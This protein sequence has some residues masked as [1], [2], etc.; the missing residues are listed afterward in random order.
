M[1]K[2]RSPNRAVREPVQVYLAP[3]DRMLLEQVAEATGLSRAEVLR[4]GLRTFA[5]AARGAG[6]P[7]LE[8][9][10]RLSAEEWPDA[11]AERHDE[12]LAQA[13]YPPEKPSRKA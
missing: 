3:D 12:H 11:I 9:L 7:M 4:R 13:Y 6:S 2:G 10:D 5:A 8:F 1:R